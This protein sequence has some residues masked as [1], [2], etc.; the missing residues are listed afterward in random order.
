MTETVSE[1]RCIHCGYILSGDHTGPCPSCGKIGKE[2]KVI[3]AGGAVGG[4]R[5]SVETQRSF[6]ERNRKAFIVIIVIT[7]GSPFVGLLVSGIP[8]LLI[9]LVLSAI[10]YFLGPN[11]V[12]EVVEKQYFN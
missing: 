3:G 7:V 10:S 11:A 1:V 6:S 12:T 4:G 5:A 8:G 9:G 2:L